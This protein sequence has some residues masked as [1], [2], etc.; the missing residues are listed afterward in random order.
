MR[1]ITGREMTFHQV[2][3]ELRTKYPRAAMNS[4]AVQGECFDRATKT[5]FKKSKNWLY[6]V[7]D[8][9]GELLLYYNETEA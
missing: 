8:D 7:R 9:Q 6:A 2:V 4:T 3:T 5:D 1:K